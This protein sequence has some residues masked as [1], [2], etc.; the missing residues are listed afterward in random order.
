MAKV[1][2]APAAGLRTDGLH[3]VHP[4]AASLDV[5]KIQITAA[6]RLARQQGDLLTATQE[7]SALSGGLQRLTRWLLSHGSAP[8]AWKA[9]FEALEDAGIEPILYHARFVKDCVSQC[10]TPIPYHNLDRPADS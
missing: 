6:V 2:P 5:H 3:V 8:R 1:E 7:F 4:R 9:P 10:K